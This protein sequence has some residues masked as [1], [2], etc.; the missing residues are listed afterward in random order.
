MFHSWSKLKTTVQLS[1]GRSDEAD[2]VETEVEPVSLKSVKPPRKT[3][4]LCSAAT[5]DNLIIF[6][7]PA[8]QSSRFVT[9][10]VKN[11]LAQ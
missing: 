1:N 10:T 9:V 5:R 6:Y 11:S 4:I 2:P 3:S 7:I 8:L